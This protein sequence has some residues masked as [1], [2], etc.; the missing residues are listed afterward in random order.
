MP[1]DAGTLTI[2]GPNSL[3]AGQ[4]QAWLAANGKQASGSLVCTIEQVAGLYIIEGAAQGIRGDV[5]F[6]QAVWETG[7]F[8]APGAAAL[9]AKNNF[10]GIGVPSQ[11]SAGDGWPNPQLGVR[12]HIQLLAK[13]VGGNNVQ[14]ANPDVAPAWAGRPAAVWSGLNDNWAVPG[15][16]YGQSIVAIFNG[17]LGGNPVLTSSTDGSTVVTDPAQAGGATF[18][19]AGGVASTNS[20]S[21]VAA[22]V[23]PAVD[24]NWSASATVTAS[25]FRWPLGSNPSGTPASDA[26][27]AAVTTESTVDLSSSQLGQVQL[28]LVDPDGDLTGGI[29]GLLNQDSGDVGPYLT[30]GNDVMV[31]AECQSIDENLVPCMILTLRTG[32]L[33]WMATRRVN[34]VWNG[35]SA[36]QWLEQCISEYNQQLPSGVPKATFL[37]EFTEPYAGGIIANASLPVT[38]W[39]SY[40][41]IAQQ[42]CFDEGMWLFEAGGV[43]VFGKPS[44]IATVSPTVKIGWAGSQ[45]FPIDSDA[46]EVMTYPRCLR[47]VSLFTGDTMEVDLPRDLGEQLRPGHLLELSGVP[48]W[49][50]KT[51]IVTGVQ[52]AFDG[53]ETPVTVQANEN[54]D[55]VPA[56][57][58]GVAPSPPQTDPT[59]H[60]PTPTSLEFVHA[61]MSQLGVP[62]AWGG[63]S[64]Q[65]GFDCSGLVEWALGQLGVNWPHYSGDQYAHCAAA[66][67]AITPAQAAEIYGAL[68]FKDSPGGAIAGEH[69][70][71]SL[72][73]TRNNGSEV[74][75]FQAPYTGATVGPAWVNI[76]YFNEGARVPELNYGTG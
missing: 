30:W 66:G 39:Q 26:L 35:V 44:F 52:F 55:P 32:C 63:T 51:W 28:T 48:Y 65:A 64:P 70:A 59:G 41:D 50:A 54:K 6:C 1:A 60:P 23:L 42:L 43:V 74:R 67:Q 12:A 37:G 24:P 22:G 38:Q 40:Y 56:A 72:G 71:I 15:T 68:L 25:T 36:T 14:L 13:A 7:W 2:T 34:K 5:A 33:Q 17:I 47:S 45:S 3:T 58:G 31:V 73:Q 16:G 21:E 53:G 27:A 18:N 4:L 20:A 19:P 46:V 62:Y 75:V 8:A 69:V 9:L 76:S 11:F 49:S 57:P 61:A 29:P 10:A